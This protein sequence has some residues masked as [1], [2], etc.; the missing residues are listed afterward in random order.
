MKA[1]RDAWRGKIPGLDADRLVF[2]DETWAST[3]MTRTRGRAPQGKRLVSAVP[4]GH[5][6][7]TTF[8]G[9]LRID[10]LTAPAV[11]D[12]PVNGE[13]FRAYV[14]QNLVKTLR[15]GDI[16]VMDNPGSHK[17]AG[18]R[19]A[20]QAAGASAVYLPPYSPDFNPI[21]NVFSKF[22]RRLRRIGA[23][24]VRALWRAVGDCLD[25]FAPD[26]C[27]ND[28]RHCGYCTLK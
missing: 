22:K 26:E 10:G 13:A 12:R 23:R 4:H 15:P 3:N 19:E 18:V 7:T 5:W 8:I 2:I 21:E 24:T 6:K 14:E 25:S 11:F 27:R 28:F 20:I 1:A 9:A 16:V 17:V